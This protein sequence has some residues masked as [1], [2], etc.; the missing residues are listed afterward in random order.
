MGYHKNKITAGVLGEFSKIQEEFEE[1]S[2]AFEQD[3]KILQ[4]CELTD[5]IGAI[6]CYISKFNL[7]INDLKSFS[8]KTKS[9]FE[10]GTR[11][12][13]NKNKR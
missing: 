9:S 2:D 6:E 12:E 8:D 11:N 7:T 5:L 1:L 3:D 10:E 4:I 13:N